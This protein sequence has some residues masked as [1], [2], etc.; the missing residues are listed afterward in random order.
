ME[1]NEGAKEKLIENINV[2]SQV[3]NNLISGEQIIPKSFEEKLCCCCLNYDLTV[4][5]FKSFNLLKKKVIPS[6]NPQNE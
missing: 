1:E 5:E 2:Q 6:Y 3:R 4:A